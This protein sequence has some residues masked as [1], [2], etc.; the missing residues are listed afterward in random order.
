MT[1]IIVA[2]R[3]FANAPKMAIKSDV[4]YCAYCTVVIGY[5]FLA[6]TWDNN[7]KDFEASRTMISIR[8]VTREIFFS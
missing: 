7:K 3:S 5:C 4:I 2:F 8:K 1:K 6:V